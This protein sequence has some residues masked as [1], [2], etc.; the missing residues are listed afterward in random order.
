MA[1]MKKQYAVYKGDDLLAIGTA[2]EISEKL[3]IKKETVYFYV[4]P[5]HKR[6]GKPTV[7]IPLD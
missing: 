6:R 4:S 3:G 5:A 1:T 2:E 7:A